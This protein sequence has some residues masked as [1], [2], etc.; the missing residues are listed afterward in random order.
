MMCLKSWFIVG[1]LS[2]IVVECVDNALFEAVNTDDPIEIEKLLNSGSNINT[3]GPGGQTPLMFAVLGGKLKAAKFLLSKGPD[4]SIGENDGYTP[5]HGAGFQGRYEIAKELIKHGLDPRNKHQDGYEPIHR[6]AWG[7]EQRHMET[8]KVL[9]EAGVPHDA[10]AT[11]GKT[12]LSMAKPGTP[13]YNYLSGLK[14]EL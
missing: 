5:M 2:L 14:S 7:G 3:I 6:T 10:K 9:I 12:P 11:N 4:T 13:V 8:A 1:C